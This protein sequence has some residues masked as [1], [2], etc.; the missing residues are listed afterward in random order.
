MKVGIGTDNPLK[1]KVVKDA[2]E[3]AFDK[4]DLCPVVVDTEVAL[5]PKG[6]EVLKG[7]LNRARKALESNDFGVGIESGTMNFEG[8]IFVIG[9]C[10]IIDKNGR[11]SIGSQPIFELPKVFWK[12]VEAGEEFGKLADEFFKTKNIRQTI[13]AVGM[14]SNKL[15]TR[16]YLMRAAVLTALIPWIS[17]NIYGD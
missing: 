13:G 3:D 14:L 6:E 17:K 2:F 8:R 9:Y 10:V 16:E 7:A 15:V 4:I 11:Y 5:Q 1:N 12:R